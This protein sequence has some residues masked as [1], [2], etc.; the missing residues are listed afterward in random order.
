MQ[1]RRAKHPPLSWAAVLLLLAAGFV[2]GLTV[3]GGGSQSGEE[4]QAVVATPQAF[5]APDPT[6]VLSPADVAEVTMPAVVN[7]STDK[8]VESNW[9]HPFMDDPFFRRFFGPPRGEG[10]ERVERSLGSG[11]VISPDGYILT[12]SHVVEMASK[13]RITFEGNEEYEAEVI[14][15]DPQTDVALIKIDADN[16]P[17]LKFGDSDALR[18][19]E[20]VMA[21]GNP[22]GLGQ[23]V[24]KGIVSA[25]GRSI[26]LI[27]YEDL[28]QTDATIN[29]GN[30]GGALVNLRGE[31]VGMS[32]AIVSRS[33]GS[34]GI[35]FAI[36]SNMALQIMDSLRDHGKVVR[37]WLGVTI[38]EV[39]QSIADYYGMDRPRGVLI[40]SVNEDTPAERAGLREGDIILSVDS[41]PIESVSE[42]RNLV[43]LSPVGEEV[44][45]R[46][47]RDGREKSIGVTL[48]ELPAEAMLASTGE[49][50]G[51]EDDG[52]IEG[53]KV[54][55]LTPQ[56]RRLTEVPDDIEGVLVVDVDRRS[57]ASR[58][59]LAAGDVIVEVN[60]KKVE[61]VSDYRRLVKQEDD[62]PILLRVYKPQSG[63]LLFMAIPR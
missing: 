29:P 53:V 16:L 22:F 41:E 12:N 8:V 45:L 44:D 38:R 50:I 36:P 37:A 18:I 11:V 5:A 20:E 54:H 39:N 57:N 21:I 43:S 3:A 7:I 42:L 48:D 47:L 46:V 10:Q 52:G 51:G 6:G 61:D 13:I 26:G 49:S 32:T 19:G 2:G 35:G 60:K 9:Q 27:D 56:R 30:S 4:I 63:G 34:Q 14:G 28:I 1:S 55:S 40:N 15:T 62:K 33:G 25:I 31:L 24:T 17:H 59:G 58:E 23:T